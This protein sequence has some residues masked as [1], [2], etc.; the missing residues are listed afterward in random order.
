MGQ[1][2]SGRNSAGGDGRRGAESCSAFPDWARIDVGMIRSCLAQ[3]VKVAGGELGK[4]DDGGPSRF[5]VPE[6]V[7][8][9]V[10]GRW[11]LVAH[12]AMSL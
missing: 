5:G 2:P 10:R 3:F 8:R 9:L 11:T 6:V 7:G 12:L 4:L 1:S